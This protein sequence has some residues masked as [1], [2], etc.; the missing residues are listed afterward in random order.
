MMNELT[1][2]DEIVNHETGEIIEPTIGRLAG[3]LA[4]AQSAIISPPR[5]KE[6]EVE[7]TT[8]SGKSYKYK[9]RYA[10]LD[11]I[12]DGVRGPLTD[13]GLWFTQ[14]LETNGDGKYVLRTTLLH[15]SGERLSSVTPLFVDGGNNQA[16]GSALTYMRRYALTAMLGVAADEDDDANGADGNK[17][18]KTKD[19]RKAPDI[20]EIDRQREEMN[21]EFRDTVGPPPKPHLIK[22]PQLGDEQKNWG[23]WTGLFLMQVSNAQTAKEIDDWVLAND[24]ML[25][26]LQAVNPD[27]HK[28]MKADIQKARD[29]I[30][31]K[32]P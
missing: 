26:G 24:E 28:R 29:A 15:E 14:T 19:R 6:V 7:G 13:N 8:K 20:E 16:F 23:K 11:A 17:V 9:F 10:T 4:K 18:E 31:G 1:P 30:A 32:E 22:P 27:W 21:Q 5:N 3:A 2:H 12:I 25:N